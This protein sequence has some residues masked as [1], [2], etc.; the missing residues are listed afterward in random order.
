MTRKPDPRQ[1]D[2]FEWAGHR[3]T[4]E[5]LNAISAIARRMW[6]ERFMHFP[7]TNGV[8]VAMPIHG[9]QGRPCGRLP[10]TPRPSPASCSLPA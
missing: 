6:Q 2:L 3:P 1:M 9:E 10:T 7:E 4:G 8:I 5:I